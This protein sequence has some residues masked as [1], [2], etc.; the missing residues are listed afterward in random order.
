MFTGRED[1]GSGLMYYRARYYDPV[2]GRFVSEDPL[3]FAAGVNFYNYVGG[4]PVN[5]NDPMGGQDLDLCLR[6]PGP[7]EQRNRPQ[8]QG[9]QLQA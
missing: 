1:G 5:A 2:I 3:G 4:D 7:P 9:H 6:R 8:W